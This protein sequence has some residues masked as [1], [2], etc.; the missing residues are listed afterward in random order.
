MGLRPGGTYSVLL[1]V[2]GNEALA[3]TVTLA[4]V[5][6]INPDDTGQPD[7]FYLTSDRDL[8]ISRDF[9]NFGG[10]VISLKRSLRKEGVTVHDQFPSYGKDFRRLLGIESEQAMEL[11]HQTVSMKSVGDLNEF[12]RSHMLE[13]LDVSSRIDALVTHFSD[14]TTAHAAV[15]RAK[16]QLELLQPLLDDAE[17]YDRLVQTVATLESERD[18]VGAVVAHEQIHQLQ[19]RLVSLDSERGELASALADIHMEQTTTQSSR[20]NLHLRAASLGGDRLLEIDREVTAAERERD[21]RQARSQLFGERLATLSLPPA[22]DEASFATTISA[23]ADRDFALRSA[24]NQSLSQLL[25]IR[26]SQ[27]ELAASANEIAAELRNLRER[28][29]NIPAPSISLRN[30]LCEA[31]GLDAD[32]LPFAGELIQVSSGSAEWEGAAERVLHGFA[33]SLLVPQHHYEAVSAWINANH[34][35]ARLVYHRVPSTLAPA[36][37]TPNQRGDLLLARLDI[38]ASM[39]LPWLQRELA[40]RAD[41]VCA[42]SLD[43]FRQAHKAITRAGQVRNGGRHEK[44]DRRP[45][46]DRTSYVLGWSTEAKLAAVLEQAA[47]THA[48]QQSAESAIQE[49][50]LEITAHDRDLTTITRLSETTRWRDLNWPE[51]VKRIAAL[52]TERRQ[53]EAG[54]VELAQVRADLRAADELLGELARRSGELTSRDGGLTTRQETAQGQLGDCQLAFAAANPEALTIL[55]PN[56][57]ARL[58]T[59]PNTFEEWLPARERLIASVDADL[60]R[61]H[62]EL[63]PL[64]NRI[65]SKMGGFRRDYPVET[66]E[67]DDNVA[68]IPGYR[69]LRDRLLGDDLPRFEADFKTALNT[70]TIRDMATLQ[71]K[72]NEQRDVTKQRI[73]IINR[74]LAG[75]D[76]NPGTYIELELQDSPNV[77]VRNFRAEL[78]ACTDN[79]LDTGGAQHYS[80]EKFLQVSGIVERFRGREGRTEAD[81]DWTKRVTDVRNWFVFTASEKSTEDG[82]EREHYTDS[83]G[84]SGGQKEKLAYTIL[85]ASL[86]YQ[87]KLDSGERTFRFVVIDEA[88]GRGSDASTRFALRLFERLGLQLLI[89]TPLQKI[90]VIERYVR[91]VG[92]VDNETGAFSRLQSLTVEE[93]RARRVSRLALEAAA[94]V[95]G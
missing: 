6:W 65:V 70:N 69:E 34:L 40:H 18:L 35:N 62:D 38:K 93:Y 26:I 37:E 75:I 89:V 48:K 41:Y 16:D 81:R 47:V 39:F 94:A 29:S 63:R 50:D 32:Q 11:F 82:S 72:L 56:L 17:R 10:D 83:G 42:E 33:L 49:L 90:Q 92:F 2:F 95:T 28:P 1:G 22:S 79:S 23:L 71:A 51:A 76:Y 59:T 64:G 25:E 44:D 14:L 43:E 74:S 78:R 19:A 86:A 4:Q 15:R 57:L 13:R 36:R 80:E 85:A 84:K 21:D 30:R 46:D 60:K 66:A 55:G 53:L 58:R 3:S 73:E 91:A 12:V 7:R 87:F 27:K 20:D 52:E 31:G 54:S 68:A 67:L 9:A 61:S 8:A 45:I 88:F 77:E 5:F 24:R